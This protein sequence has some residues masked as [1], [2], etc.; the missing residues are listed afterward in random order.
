MLTENLV[1]ALL[2]GA[3]GALLVVWITDALAG[4]H[5]PTDIPLVI[6]AAPDVRVF[7]FALLVSFLTTLLFGLLPALQAARTNLAGALKN[8]AIS[9]RLRHWQLRDYMVATQVALSAV[10]LVCSVLVVRSLQRALDAPIGYNPRGAVTASFDLNIQGYN[11]SRGREFE[12]RLLDKVRA[13]PGIQAAAIVELA[14][15]LLKY[16][17]GQHLHRRQTHNEG[18]RDPGCVQLLR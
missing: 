16:V 15:A 13:I 8:E 2:G 17:F 7:L 9:E 5:P 4:W 11:E 10:L 3:G 14:A 1:I 12:R 18:R 6:S